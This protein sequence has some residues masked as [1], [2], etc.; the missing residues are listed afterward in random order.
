MVCRGG[1]RLER[2]VPPMRIGGTYTHYFSASPCPPRAKAPGKAQ[3]L[4]WLA[5]GGSAHKWIG[6]RG[7]IMF[8]SWPET[9]AFAG[10]SLKVQS[11]FI[12]GSRDVGVVQR[13][14]TLRAMESAPGYVRTCMVEGAGHWVQQEQPTKVV[15][16]VLEFLDQSQA[17]AVTLPDDR[18]HPVTGASL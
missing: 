7:K 2:Y 13:P 18:G 15:Q 9:K 11:C 4:G 10:A 8:L 14:G 3:R 16:C 12:A 1:P 17:V 6:A 5:D